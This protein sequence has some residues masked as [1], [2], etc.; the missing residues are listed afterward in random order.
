MLYKYTKK[1]LSVYSSSR[2]YQH[3]NEVSNNTNSINGTDFRIF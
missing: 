3:S 1:A 2:T